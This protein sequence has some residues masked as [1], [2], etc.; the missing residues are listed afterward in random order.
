MNIWVKIFFLVLLVSGCKPKQKISPNLYPDCKYGYYTKN[1]AKTKFD[2][3]AIDFNWMKIKT[4]VEVYYENEKHSVQLQIRLKNDSLIFAKISKSG[5]TGVRILATKDSVIYVDK[6]KKQ[7]YKG[8]YSDIEKLLNV[9]IPFDLLQNLFLGEPTFLYDGEGEKEVSE[10]LIKYS[11]NVFDDTEN[12]SAF[13][14]VHFF[15]CDSMKLQKVGVTDWKTKKEILVEYKK[16][17]DINGYPLNKKIEFKGMQDNKP[18]ILA[19]VEL[20]RVKLFDD[21]SVFIEIPDDYTE[22]EIK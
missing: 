12:Y 3:S 17:G 6:L 15:T 5:I 7:F 13:H 8:G 1:Q 10:P 18:F 14:Q 16:Q 19:D 9:N 2:S 4:K 22:M 20:K 11:S 21:L